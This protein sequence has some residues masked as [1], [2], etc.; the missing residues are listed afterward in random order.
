MSGGAFLAG[1]RQLASRW[2]PRVVAHAAWPGLSLCSLVLQQ[3]E[4][5][6]R[7]GTCGAPHAGTRFWWHCWAGAVPASGRRAPRAHLSSCHFPL[8]RN[9]TGKSFTANY[10]VTFMG[11]GRLSPLAW[12]PGVGGGSRSPSC[13]EHGW[14]GSGCSRAAVPTVLAADQWKQTLAL[15]AMKKV[16]SYVRPKFCE[17]GGGAEPHTFLVPPNKAGGRAPAARRLWSGGER[18]LPHQIIPRTAGWP[19]RSL[20]V[21]DTCR[22]HGLY[23]GSPLQGSDSR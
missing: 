2:S 1:R 11:G 15:H 5:E 20:T 16:A 17:T 8:I 4:E 9:V 14:Q 22:G 18:C 7:A 19:Q 3:E 6:M 23:T 13:R 10:F 12:V 21:D